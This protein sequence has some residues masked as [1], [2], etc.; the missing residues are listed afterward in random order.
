MKELM[1]YIISFVNM[2]L[3]GAANKNQSREKVNIEKKTAMV[4]S[5]R[6]P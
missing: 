5:H 1:L 3:F 6:Q 4:G 2:W